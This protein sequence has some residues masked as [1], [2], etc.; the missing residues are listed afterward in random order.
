MTGEP[1]VP[2]SVEMVFELPGTAE[3]VWQAIATGPGISSWFV[4]TDVDERLGGSYVTHMGETDSPGR[5]TGWEPNRR[6][7]IEEPEWAALAGHEGEPVTPLATEFLIEAQAG[8]TCV[9]RVVTSA[10]GTGADWE[11]EFIDGMEQGWRPY[12]DRLRLYLAHFPGQHATTL[13]VTRSITGQEYDAVL[14]AMCESLGVD[15]AD[16][17]TGQVVEA[18]GVKGQ[19]ERIDEYDVLMRVTDPVPGYLSIVAWGAGED[20]S[21]PIVQAMVQGQFFSGDAP[22]FVERERPG[23]QEWLEGF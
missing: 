11:Q 19:V 8:G 6:F 22:G 5:V 16:G 3:Q 17:G 21:Q 14:T 7:A 18:R 9:L 15:R 12:F 2:L 4:P 23:W 1:D 10:F 20:D 13:E